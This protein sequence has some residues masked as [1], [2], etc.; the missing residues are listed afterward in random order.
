VT[1]WWQYQQRKIAVVTLPEEKSPASIHT[2]AAAPISG[3]P[4]SA[5]SV[6]EERPNKRVAMASLLGRLNDKSIEFYGKVIDQN[7]VPIPGVSVKG[8]VIYNNGL[9]SGVEEK[10]SIT[11][12]DGLFS[13]TGMRGRTFDCALRKLGYMT[14]PE[15]DAWDYTEFVPPEKRHHP[16]PQKPVVLKMWK[17]QGAEPMLYFERTGFDILPDGTQLRINLMTGKKVASG[18]DLVI[19]LKHPKAEK[20]QQR[21]EHSP[22][23]AQFIVAGGGFVESTA[24][25][26]YL[27]PENGY[28]E[29]LVLGVTGQEPKVYWQGNFYV[30]QS[31]A[32]KQYYLKLGNGCY[33]R[34]IV[35]V[36]AETSPLFDSVVSLQWW[37]NPKPGSRNLEYDPAKVPTP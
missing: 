8:S 6:A 14:M 29:K 37:L 24:R 11:D 4:V 36:L 32:R 12:V 10:E 13:F 30:N 1:F 16:D 28:V 3:A 7:G 18:G 5:A 17:L 25:L 22:W 19:T 20:G 9:S 31:T 33:A 34:V 2:P 21:L 27:A 23:T 15:G 26:M 35:E